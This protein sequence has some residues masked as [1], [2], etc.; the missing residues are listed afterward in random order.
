[1]ENKEK[2]DDGFTLNIYSPGN[3][4]AKEMVF[5]GPINIGMDSNSLK[6][7]GFTDNQIAQAIEQICGRDKPLN[8]KQL[9]AGVYWCL[10]WYCNFPVKGTDFCDRVKTLPFSKKL[11]PECDLENFRKYINLSFMGQ[12]CRKMDEVKPSK[13][14]EPVFVQLRT[15]VLALVE[16]LGKTNVPKPKLK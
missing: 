11:D 5:E 4:I 9:W 15:V 1:M 6:Q 14:D 12:D 2:I 8:I 13:M 7:N 3:F 10:R 16:E